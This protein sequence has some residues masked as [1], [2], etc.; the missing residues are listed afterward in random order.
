MAISMGRSEETGEYDDDLL[1]PDEVDDHKK[2]TNANATDTSMNGGECYDKVAYPEWTWNNVNTYAAI[3]RV[4]KYDDDQIQALAKQDIVFLEKANGHKAYGSVEKGSLEAAK[5][6]KKINS[7]VKILF[8][9]NA[10]VHYNDYAA[11]KTFEKGWALE[12]NGELFKWRDKFLS[13]DHTNEDFR[14]WWITRAT[15]M[16]AHKEIDGIFIDALCKV[17][18]MDQSDAWL[19]T[20]RQ[21]RECMPEGKL[22]IGNAI[23]AKVDRKGNWRMM[24]YLDGSYLENWYQSA[25]IKRKTLP[26]MSKCLKEGRIVMLNAAPNVD[27]ET[28]DSIETLDDR[29]KFLNQP[30]YI[31]FPL[32]Y[33]LLVVEPYA[34]FSFH[35]GVDAMSKKKCVWENNK[36]DAITRKLGKPLGDYVDEGGGNYSR[37]FVHLKVHANIKTLVGK[38]TVKEKTEVGAPS[39]IG[40]D[41]L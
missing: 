21:L 28:I 41:E 3:R 29:Y 20:A 30:S 9:L 35:T 33:F 18:G 7:K 32:G 37:E 27:A 14:E 15:D 10:M 22:L 5:R 6:I 13:Y 25:N 23:R 24:Q 26:L 34:Y 39:V 8:Y 17:V 38:L 4:D 16:L 12:R 31:D 1:V 40:K 19:V 36:F 2:D 11:N